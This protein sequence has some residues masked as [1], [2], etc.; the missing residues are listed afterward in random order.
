[1][2]NSENSIEVT[3]LSK[4]FK[5]YFDKSNTLKEK[6]IHRKRNRHEIR[7]VLDCLSFEIKKGEAVGLIGSNGCG[8]STTLKL[9]SKII[10]PDSGKIET[11]GRVSSLIELGAGFHPD[12][13]GRENIYTN[14][15]IFG[16]S[17]KEIDQRLDTII[18]FSELEEYID[19]PVRTYSSGMYMRLA[20]SVA[21]NV[22]ADILL[23]DEILAVG[24]IN[25]Q[26][27]CLDKIKQ[28]K[29]QGT[30]IVIVSH[31]LSQIQETCDRVIWLEKGKVREDGKPESVI[32]IYSREMELARLTKAR[33]ENSD[34]EALEASFN[35]KILRRGTGSVRFISVHIYDNGGNK[36]DIFN[37]GDDFTIVAEYEN[38]INHVEDYNISFSIAKTDGSLCY[39]TNT[40][41]EDMNFE[42]KEK[43]KIEIAIKNCRLVKGQ[44]LVNLAISGQ[45][46][47][48]VDDL[49]RAVIFNIE[50]TKDDLGVYRLDYNWSTE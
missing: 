33:K 19:N 35:K 36:Q 32:E 8:K 4:S 37:Q 16:L 12:M 48:I 15:S 20:F 24:D 14:A 25:Y 42:L 13:S 21:I 29:K 28:I 31:S 34:V 26:K 27:K 17:R 47:R 22:D 46:G 44:Y 49:Q 9:L 1:M 38:N 2:R 50:S 10:Y 6:V 23:I 18:R 40:I 45:D 3:D 39:A 11:C 30:T 5:V 7:Q 41:I 43:G